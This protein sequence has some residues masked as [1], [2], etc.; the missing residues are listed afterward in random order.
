MQLLWPDF[1]RI[2]VRRE[3]PRQSGINVSLTSLY[4]S[5]SLSTLAKYEEKEINTPPF[6]Y[7]CEHSTSLFKDMKEMILYEQSIIKAYSFYSLSSPAFAGT[8][9]PSLS[10][11]T[12]NSSNRS[13]YYSKVTLTAGIR[14]VTRRV[15]TWPSF[16]TSFCVCRWLRRRFRRFRRR[17]SWLRSSQR[18]GALRVWGER[19]REEWGIVR[20]GEKSWKDWW[21]GRKRRRRSVW[22]CCGG[23]L[24]RD[25]RSRERSRG[26][27]RRQIRMLLRGVFV[28]NG[29]E[30]KD[31]CI[32]E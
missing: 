31:G 15:A 32:D 26:R 12:P 24:R 16:S 9:V 25:I 7:F 20:S 6:S 13:E 1:A 5:A 23:C 21:G 27:N 3:I 11:I 30:G 4:A 10:L 8:S 18:R 19:E 28:W 14:S 17:F 2:P 22:E 29:I